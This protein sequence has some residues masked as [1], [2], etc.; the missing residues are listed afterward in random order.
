MVNEYDVIIVGAGIAGLTA[1]REV[2]K[3]DP[4]LRVCILEGRNRLGGRLHTVQS[5]SGKVID[6]GGMWIGPLQRHISSLVVSKP[7][8]TLLNLYCAFSHSLIINITSRMNYMYL[9]IA[10]T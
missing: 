6:L 5:N 3:F 7:F 4:T 1:A 9:Y 2:V 8:S 10:S